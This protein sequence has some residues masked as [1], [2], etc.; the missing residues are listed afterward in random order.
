MIESKTGKKVPAVENNGRITPMHSRF[1][2]EKEG[3]R[4]PQV[5]T[6]RGFLLFF[7]FGG[8]YH[9]TPFLKDETVEKIVIIEK[10]LDFFTYVLTQ[11]DL[12]DL[13]FDKRVVLLVEEEQES[14]RNSLLTHYLPI[15]T[16]DIQSILLRPSVQ[17]D[18]NYYNEIAELIRET[19]EQVSDD[20]TVQTRFGKKWFRNTVANLEK[21]EKAI[22]KI[23]SIGKAMITAAGPSLDENIEKIRSMR[24]EIFLIATDTS[25]PAL[26]H[27]SIIPDIVISI[28][29]QDISYNHF[30]QGYPEHVPLLLDLASPTRLN[31]FTDNRLY[32]SSGHPFSRYVNRHF[33]NFPQIDT[34]G[35]NVTYAAL[36]L[37]VSLGARE[38][39]VSGADF[40]YPR[41]KSYAMET[42]LYPWFRNLESRFQSL[43]S[44]FFSF[45][46][47][48]NS[49]IRDD[50][51]GFIRYISKPMIGYRKLFE[52][53]ATAID[54]KVIPL[55]GSGCELKI[56]NR[57]LNPFPS[58]RPVLSA[59]S[60][61]M[62]SKKFLGEYLKNLKM[63]PLPD[64]P[65]WRYREKLTD[66]ELELITTVLP[67]AAEFSRK[68]SDRKESLKKA[69][70][71]TISLLERE[72]T[73][74]G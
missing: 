45:I 62:S 6:S 33:R 65:L 30:M 35:G 74:T 31:R 48:N 15:L 36:S 25:L 49:M 42:Y 1:D 68:F 57:K 54:P 60:P 37:A 26:L 4:F 3:S 59:G 64:G 66:S 69:I 63:L 58:I 29:C 11:M 34:S 53:A 52:A 43:E 41:G 71:W 28:D 55:E 21:A 2:P 67:A 19:L 39:Y 7:G 8:A 5:Y 47:H 16:G 10:N 32:F 50:S 27:R 13:L 51:D 24:K 38:I 12:T 22:F 73:Q 56:S 46:M 44:F 70:Q 20:L 18:E 17:M 61:M 23:G 40:S 72:I 9:I 14:I